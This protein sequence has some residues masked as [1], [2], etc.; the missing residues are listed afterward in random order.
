MVYT[1]LVKARAG[2]H[3]KETYAGGKHA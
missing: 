1:L 3:N 2:N